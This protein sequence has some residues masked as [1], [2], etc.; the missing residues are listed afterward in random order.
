MK[1][2]HTSASCAMLIIVNYP[3]ENSFKGSD[4]HL[5]GSVTQWIAH[6]HG[7]QGDLSSGLGSS[8]QLLG[9]FG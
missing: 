5:G 6:Q 7:L 9:D 8:T 2:Y 4:L 1:V 3:E